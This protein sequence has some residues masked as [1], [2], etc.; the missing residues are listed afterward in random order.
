[1]SRP[2]RELIYIVDDDADVRESTVALLESHGLEVRGFASGNDFL[3][4]FDPEIGGC[5]ILDVHMPDISGMRILDALQLEGRSVPVVFC[6]GH[7]EGATEELA[8]RSGAAAVLSK[9][10]DASELI[11]LIRRLISSGDASQDI[12]GAIAVKPAQ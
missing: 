4:E 6:T 1:M 2:A 7:V 11:S 3:R 8:K 9:P 10:V 12:R 5:V